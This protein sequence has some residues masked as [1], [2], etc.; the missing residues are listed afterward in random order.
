MTEQN[1]KKLQNRRIVLSI[2]KMSDNSNCPGASRTISL[3]LRAESAA[4]VVPVIRRYVKPGTRIQTDDG[5]A[6]TS[7][8]AW[9]DHQTVCHS[10]EYSTD[11][12]INNNQAES[13][14]GRMRRAEYGVYHGMR[15]QYL[16]FYAA[17]IA[18]RED[19][20]QLSVMKKINDLFR[21]IFSCDISLAF[22]G[23]AQGHRLKHEYLG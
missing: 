14:M 17:E 1:R 3:I 16:A 7:L 23:Y 5:H 12:G 8:S 21:R 22:R 13:F 15:P 2:R 9:Y 11:D 19:V 10:I 18:W 20:R 6:Y 4:E